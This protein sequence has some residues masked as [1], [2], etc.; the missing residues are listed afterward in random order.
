MHTLLGALHLDANKT[1]GRL[2]REYKIFNSI[3][4]YLISFIVHPWEREKQQHKHRNGN[5]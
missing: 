5:N 1:Q 4:Y 3:N 2:Q